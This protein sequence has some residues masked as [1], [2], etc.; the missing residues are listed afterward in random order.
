[1]EFY[2][3]RTG[4]V[5]NTVTSRSS[6]DHNYNK[7]H[8]MISNNELGTLRSVVQVLFPLRKATVLLSGRD[9]ANISSV[10]LTIQSV[11]FQ[12]DQIETKIT[13]QELC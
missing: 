6:S 3:E 1:M 10:I 12:L 8:P 7:C 13:S 2:N 9:L 5:P 11:Y 4:K